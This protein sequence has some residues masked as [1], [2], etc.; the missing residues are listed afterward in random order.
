MNSQLQSNIIQKIAVPVLIAVIALG[1]GYY[2]G[3]QN[4]DQT[5]KEIFSSGIFANGANLFGE[6]TAIAPD[7]SSLSVKVSTAMSAT[8]P[9]EYQNKT[10]LI[11]GDTKIVL[12]ENK[13]P[14]VLSEE[15]KKYDAAIKKTKNTTAS[16]PP[17]PYIE[18]EIAVDEL[19]IGDAVDFS[20]KSEI[21]GNATLLNH[22]FTALTVTVIR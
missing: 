13:T 18:K 9:K 10:V 6:I 3:R 19:K 16:A 14:E 5:L 11:T 22:Q 20:F 4:Q 2:A 12:R 7:K 21:S 8:L 1:V 15:M 17:L